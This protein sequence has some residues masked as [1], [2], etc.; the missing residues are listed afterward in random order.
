MLCRSSGVQEA[1]QILGLKFS[2]EDEKSGKVTWE[3]KARSAVQCRIMQCN[4]LQCRRQRGPLRAA[5][6]CTGRWS[7]HFKM[8]Y[9]ETQQIHIHKYENIEETS[10]TVATYYIAEADHMTRPSNFWF[11][12]RNKTQSKRKQ[13][14]RLPQQAN[15]LGRSSISET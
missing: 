9:C 2:S 8:R 11:T 14:R 10:Q 15:W 7:Q 13:K 1:V 3:Q 4:A 5:P 6:A 12:T